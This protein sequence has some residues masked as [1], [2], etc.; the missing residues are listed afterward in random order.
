MKQVLRYVPDFKLEA[1]LELCSRQ[2]WDVA[3]MTAMRDQAGGY[4]HAVI[5]QRERTVH[6]ANPIAPEAPEVRWDREK[7]YVP[8]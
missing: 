3:A 4:I 2:G 5:V 6:D 1:F 7:G 8:A